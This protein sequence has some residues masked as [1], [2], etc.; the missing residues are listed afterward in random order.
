MA[1]LCCLCSC[2]K[3]R[4]LAGRLGK[5]S[6]PAAAATPFAGPLVSDIAEADY[7]SFRNL[8]GR[9][10]V[11]DFHGDRCGLCHQLAPVLVRI[12]AE[13]GGRVLVGRI[14]VDQAPSLAMKEDVN[15]LPDVRI[16][17]DGKKVDDFV[18]MPGEAEVRRRIEVHAKGLP[19]PPPPPAGGGGSQPLTRPMPKD[20]M[21]E[22]MQRR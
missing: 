2:D 14:N 11:I 21:P 16:Y 1:V 9:V 19:A 5:P 10:I 6:K 3:V 17:R 15:G 4:D 13:Q 18:G 7:E 12:A 8:P 20:W 22:G